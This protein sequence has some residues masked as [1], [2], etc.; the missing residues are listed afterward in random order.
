MSAVASARLSLSRIRRES[1]RRVLVI[2]RREVRDTMRDWRIVTPIILLTLVFPVLMDFTADQALQWA[3]RYGGTIVGER[4]IP[5][6]LMVVGFFP[7]SFSL[8]IALETFV[9]EKE[10]RSL[11]PLLATPLS[12]AE[13]YWGKMLAAMIPPVAASYLG[14]GV[15]LAGLYFTLHYVAELEL[16]AVIVALTT[17]KALVMVSGAVVVSSQT[18]SVRAANL[19]ASFIIIPMALLIQGESIIMFWGRYDVLWWI[20]A[21]LMMANVILVRMGVHIFNREELLGREIDEINLRFIW[22][23]LKSFF[24]NSPRDDRQAS[25]GATRFNLWHV[26]RYDLPLLIGRQWLPIAVVTLVLLVGMLL[27]WGYAM[28]YPL[29]SEYLPLDEIPEEAFQD[30]SGVGFLPSFNVSAVF[31]NNVRALTLGA[32]LALFSF[33][34]LA[35]IQMMLPMVIIGFFVGEAFLLGYNPWVFFAAFILPHGIVELPAAVIATAFAL[36]MGASV[37]SPP[38]GLTV[39]EGLLLTLADFLKVFLFLV[40]PS[41]LIAAALEIW[42]TPRIVLGIYGAG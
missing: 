42:V 34:S 1:L 26:Y 19:L 15:Y 2:V 16:L 23:R 14:L 3:A 4:A 7:I 21:V 18:T 28:R 13:L 32:L 27:G 11:E 35:L 41:L 6:L 22:R 31:A 25:A 37:V 29:P 36:R 38:K 5:F 33:G 10:R 8:V 39:S 12:N 20:V 24:L 30:L 40:L 17:A 9:G